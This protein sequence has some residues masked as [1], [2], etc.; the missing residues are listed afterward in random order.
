MVLSETAVANVVAMKIFGDA[1]GELKN[2]WPNNP[3]G[4]TPAR[5]SAGRYLVEL[6]YVGRHYVPIRRCWSAVREGARLEPYRRGA[7]TTH[8]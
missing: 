2:I 7:S 5:G 4:S 3:Y 6:R 8:S 1:G